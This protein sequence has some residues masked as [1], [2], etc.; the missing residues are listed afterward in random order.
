MSTNKSLS[1]VNQEGLYYFSPLLGDG[2]FGEE[3][4]AK[5]T[6]HQRKL[7]VEVVRPTTHTEKCRL[8]DAHKDYMFWF[9]LLTLP[10]GQGTSGM[11]RKCCPYP[12]GTEGKIPPHPSTGPGG[13]SGGNSV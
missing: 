2:T 3:S 4:V 1:V 5:I 8:C 9:T 7:Q 10:K 13:I 6:Y 11:M 12:E